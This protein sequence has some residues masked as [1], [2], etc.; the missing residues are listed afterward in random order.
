MRLL[1]V[2]NVKLRLLSSFWKRQRLFTLSPYALYSLSSALAMRPPRRSIAMRT[3]LFSSTTCPS[4]PC[5]AGAKGP[6]MAATCAANSSAVWVGACAARSASNCCAICSEISLA[7]NS[8]AWTRA[9]ESCTRLRSANSSWEG[10]LINEN[11]M[12]IA[13]IKAKPIHVFLSIILYLIY[14]YAKKCSMWFK[15]VQYCSK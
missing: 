2:T 11:P 13:A 7:S 10:R 15:I 4:C 1:L 9:M 3:L 12:T 8:C 5:A 14:Y 6:Y